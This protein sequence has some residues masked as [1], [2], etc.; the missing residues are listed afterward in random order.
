MIAIR[1][2]TSCGY[3]KLLDAFI[4]DGLIE[5][6][7]KILRDLGDDRLKKIE[8]KPQHLRTPDEADIREVQVHSLCILIQLCYRA[9][10]IRKIEKEKALDKV[11]AMDSMKWANKKNFNIYVNTVVSY[12]AENQS[13][14]LQGPPISFCKII[15]RYI[16]DVLLNK[17]DN[18][19]DFLGNLD[20]RWERIF[21]ALM[22]L[23][24]V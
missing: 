17:E 21:E 3:R 9:E 1:Q 12:C 8:L 6:L 19:E 11:K 24:L 18:N 10:N 23:S 16:N 2:A 14:R 22:N 13:I 5:C 7:V 20:K 15:F 4:A